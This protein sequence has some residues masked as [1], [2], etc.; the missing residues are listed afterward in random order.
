MFAR[1]LIGR[2]LP[3]DRITTRRVPEVLDTRQAVIKTLRATEMRSRRSD[4]GCAGML[5][6]EVSMPAFEKS[7]WLSSGA[8]VVVG[9]SG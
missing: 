8:G 2:D 6:E 9:V 1:G 7:T 3:S 5:A 4:E